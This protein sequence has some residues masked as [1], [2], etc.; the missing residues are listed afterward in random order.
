MNTLVIGQDLATP[1]AAGVRGCNLCTR[2]RGAI[3]YQSDTDSQAA[4]SGICSIAQQREVEIDKNIRQ[5]TF[6][7]IWT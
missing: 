7:T 4:N 5:H 3:L 6:I 2:Q 1:L